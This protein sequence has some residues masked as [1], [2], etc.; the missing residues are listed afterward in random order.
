M[1]SSHTR[2]QWR[3]LTL[4]AAS[5]VFTDIGSAWPAPV[6]DALDRP[7][8]MSQHAA[9]AVL[10]S[11]AQAGSRLIAVGERGIVV[12]SDDDGASWRQVPA[13]VSVTLTAVRFA[14]SKHGFAVGHAGTVIS[15]ADGGETWTRRLDGRHAA[16]LVQAAA[17]TSGDEQTVL[18]A[19]R[20]V[21]DGPDKPLLDLLVLDAQHV[22]VVGAYGL[23]FSTDNGGQSW[24]SWMARLA[25]PRGFHLYA[26]RRNGERLLV[27]GEQGLVRLSEDGGQTFSSVTLPYSGSFFTAELPAD[28]GIVLAGLRGNVWRSADSGVNWAQVPVPM[29][30]SITASAM[31]ADGALVFVNQ[32]GMVLSERSGS[33][34][35]INAVPLP[36]LNGVVAK[37]DGSLLALSIQGA[38]SVKSGDLK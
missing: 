15:T 18:N 19:E 4:L 7:A 14:D 8:V 9:Q 32:A 38:V 28:D 22:V 12:V 3:A 21:A 31:R 24:T 25:N 11:A 37:P 33:L 6:A 23:A 34:V 17:K 35:P 36:P 27:A 26:I 16:Q 5:A 2:I 13:S 30:A 1:A 29:Q 20:L 10:L